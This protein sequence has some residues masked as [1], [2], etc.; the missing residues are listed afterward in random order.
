LDGS[1]PEPLSHTSIDSEPISF[2]LKL[3]EEV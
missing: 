1:I 3:H 2:N